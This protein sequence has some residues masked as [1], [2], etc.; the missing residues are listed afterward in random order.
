M[1]A[2]WRICPYGRVDLGASDSCLVLAGK[3]W[4]EIGNTWT[5]PLL[6]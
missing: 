4:T 2:I 6:K 1:T 5:V 3:G